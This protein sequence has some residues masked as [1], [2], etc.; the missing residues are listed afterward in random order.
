LPNNGHNPK[1]GY[2]PD[3]TR[4]QNTQLEVTAAVKT[5]QTTIEGALKAEFAANQIVPD[6]AGKTLAKLGGTHM[7]TMGSVWQ[8]LPKR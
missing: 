5:L 6:I 1:P 7:L 8:M 4:N 3:A 2:P